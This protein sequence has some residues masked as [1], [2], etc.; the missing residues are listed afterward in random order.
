MTSL[1]A[2]ELKTFFAVAELQAL[3]ALSFWKRGCETLYEKLLILAS[4]LNM[5]T[6]FQGK[7]RGGGHDDKEWL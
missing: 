2:E 5:V 7:I 4:R 6:M 1:Q 3:L